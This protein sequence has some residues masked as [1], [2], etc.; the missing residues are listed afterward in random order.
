MRNYARILQNTSSNIYFENLLASPSRGDYFENLLESPSRD[1]S[2]KYQK[3]MFY[4]EIRIKTHYKKSCRLNG[5][6]LATGARRLFTRI[7]THGR[8]E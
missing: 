7:I 1:D 4:E 5:K 6:M 2:I 3:H 8:T